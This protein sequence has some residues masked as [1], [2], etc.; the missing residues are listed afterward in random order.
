M[1][2]SKEIKE[3][4]PGMAF[5][6]MN[7]LYQASRLTSLLSN[8]TLSSYYGKLLKEI[9][10]K[11]VEKLHPDLKRSVCAACNFPLTA[12]SCQINVKVTPN[13]KKKKT[14]KIAIKNK[15]VETKFFKIKKNEVAQL[16]DKSRKFKRSK[17]PNNVSYSC[18]KCGFVKRYLQ[19]P[20]YELSIHKKE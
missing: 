8:S 17:Q 7:F 12:N 6:R 11:M 13:L 5:V 9:S 20:T 2:K 3:Q 14:K 19:K 4:S 10:K 15:G 16:Y 18:S 1:V